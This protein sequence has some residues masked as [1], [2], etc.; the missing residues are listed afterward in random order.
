MKHS[1]LVSCTL[2]LTA[3]LVD[4]LKL[5]IVMSGNQYRIH[6][7]IHWRFRAKDQ[8]VPVV[9]QIVLAWS[10]R[11]APS[12]SIVVFALQSPSS[13][14]QT[15]NTQP[16]NHLLLFSTHSLDFVHNNA[17]AP[18]SNF[19]RRTFPAT[20][21]KSRLATQPHSP[22]HIAIQRINFRVSQ[23]L[24]INRTSYLHRPARDRFSASFY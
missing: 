4:I 15:T 6:C 24:P 9:T 1:T 14:T 16:Q 10:P 3:P 11:T 5:S 18:S 2:Q 8:H 22:R 21:H 20:F 7:R 12:P 13:S 23:P 17:S 19:D